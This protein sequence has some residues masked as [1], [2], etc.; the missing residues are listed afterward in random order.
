MGKILTIKAK[1]VDSKDLGITEKEGYD[2]PCDERLAKKPTIIDLPL[3]RVFLNNNKNFPWVVLVPRLDVMIQNVLGLTDEQYIQICKEK[4][5]VLQALANEFD[6]VEQLNAAEFSAVVRQFHV[7]LLGRN[8]NDVD[9]P[10]SVF[11][12]SNAS[13]KYTEEEIELMCVRIKVAIKKT[14]V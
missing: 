11:D 13:V 5:A 14:M 9:W 7:H 3:C 6:E 12:S 4:R 2:F 8:S 1:E 10:K